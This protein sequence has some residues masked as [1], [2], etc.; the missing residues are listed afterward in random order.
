MEL[1]HRVQRPTFSSMGDAMQPP[2]IPDQPCA[3]PRLMGFAQTAQTD[4]QVLME[5]APTAFLAAAH[6]AVLPLRHVLYVLRDTSPLLVALK[7]CASV[8]MIQPLQTATRV[9]K[10][11]ASA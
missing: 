6:A 5:Y 10:I 8:V 3:H 9:F 1:A 7:V 4:L 11:V 2:G